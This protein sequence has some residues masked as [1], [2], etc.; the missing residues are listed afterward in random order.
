MTAGPTASEIAAAR[1]QLGKRIVA[2]PTLELNA[3]RLEGWLPEGATVFMKME[4]FQ[5]AGSFKAR[6]ATLA[7]DALTDDERTRGVTAVSAGNH[8]LAVSW[9]AAQAGVSAKV[10]M[11]ETA[12]NIRVD[13]CKALGAEVVLVANVEE[14]FREVARLR[15]EEGRAYLHPFDSPFMTLGAATIGDELATAAGHLDAAII[16]VGGGGLI[17]G[18]APA[19]KA[20]NPD[21]EIFGV[22]PE[23]ADSMHRSF[24]AGEAVT[25]E[26]VNTIADS[27]GAPMAMPDTFALTRAHVD[28]I[29]RLPDTAFPPAMEALYHAMKII[30]EPACAATLAALAGPLKTRLTGKRVGI[31]ACGS[32]ISRAKFERLCSI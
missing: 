18:M 21:C 29:I 31:I 8:A 12:D 16:P 30:A 27:L 1:E 15:D 32:N 5:Q 22:E 20:L 26:K 17:S 9:A 11:P 2:T 25:L 19:I 10:V 13:G 6:G 4:L 3:S 24:A 23:G 14:A 28:E 7:V